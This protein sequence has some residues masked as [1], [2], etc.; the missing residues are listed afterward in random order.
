MRCYDKI[1]LWECTYRYVLNGCI[2]LHSAGIFSLRG[3]LPKKKCIH[4]FHILSDYPT[5]VNT[6]QFGISEKQT[7]NI[8]YKIDKDTSDSRPLPPSS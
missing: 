1:M 4:Y 3:N 8:L 5:K 6:K 7:S 2:W